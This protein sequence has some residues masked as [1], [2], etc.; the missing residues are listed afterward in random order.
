MF[1][2]AYLA[3]HFMIRQKLINILDI[4]VDD[5]SI[6]ITNVNN[7]L[8]IDLWFA[9]RMGRI[10]QVLIIFTFDSWLWML[11]CKQLL[12]ITEQIIV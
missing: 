7:L 8:G 3:K 2:A 5:L 6:G 4:N 1:T 12:W 9:D 11:K 10:M